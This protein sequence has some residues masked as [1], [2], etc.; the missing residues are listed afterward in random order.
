MFRGIGARVMTGAAGQ[1]R[2][3][4]TFVADFPVALPPP[5]E[6][7]AIV[8]HIDRETAKIDALIGKYERELE[9]L[10]EYR[11]ALI[12]HVVTGKV[13]VRGLVGSEPAKA[14]L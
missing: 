13:D 1:Q 14:A 6:Q 12:S 5:E 2:V 4:E 7:D 11:A 8:A 10:D 3:P 9:L